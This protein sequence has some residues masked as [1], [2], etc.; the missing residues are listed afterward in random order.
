MA[1]ET[2]LERPLPQN[3]D[4]ERS[5]LGAILID[6]HSLNTAVEKLKPE[7]FFQN[8]HQLIFTQM[9]EL[10]PMLRQQGVPFEQIVFPDEVHDFLMWRD[11]VHA[12]HAGSDFF[13]RKLKGSSSGATNSAGGN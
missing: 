4:A 13:D 2:T 9:I 11:W 7:D 12:Y 10:V 1:N 5:V 6:N 3:L 8:Q